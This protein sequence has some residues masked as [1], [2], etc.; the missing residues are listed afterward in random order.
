MNVTI[1]SRGNGM[2]PQCENRRNC[3]IHTA[4][5]ATLHSIS[6]PNDSGMEL[7]IFECPNFSN[8]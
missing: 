3:E 5:S 4:L 6:D 2:C 1:N 7:V 8:N